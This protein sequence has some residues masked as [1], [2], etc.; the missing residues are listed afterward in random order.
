MYEI[1]KIL[2][3]LRILYAE[4]NEQLRDSISKTLNIIFKEVVIAKNGKEALECFS[5]NK[6]DIV[7]L[8]Y[9]MPIAN[10][11]YVCNQIR[12]IDKNIP[13][14]IASGYTEKEK[15]LEAIDLNIIKYIEKPIKFDVL[16]EAFIKSVY[17]L[18][19]INRLH[20][21]LGENVKYDYIRKI[22]IKPENLEVTLTRQEIQLLELFIKNK[23]Y[24]LT[25]DVILEKIFQ[26]YVEENTIRN[27]IYRLR[28]KLSPKTL[29][30][31]KDLGYILH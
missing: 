21:D 31:V 8:D 27:L 13:I 29:E 24:L 9:I 7:L 20:V 22:I 19:E 3:G 17:K 30:M 5:N 6:F 23:T 10:G 28:K 16:Q 12:K 2:S 18:Q 1:K 14:I 11:N 25:K 4:D 15:L 26:N